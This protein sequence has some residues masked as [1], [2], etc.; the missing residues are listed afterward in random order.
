MIEAA[1]STDSDKDK[2]FLLAMA[3]DD[4]PV[5]FDDIGKRLNAKSNVVANYL[6]RLI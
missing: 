3:E 2:D 6:A 1:L 5:V 4:G